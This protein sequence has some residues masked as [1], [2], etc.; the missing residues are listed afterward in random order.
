MNDVFNMPL[1]R[2]L[3]ISD[4]ARGAQSENN[5]GLDDAPIAQNTNAVDPGLENHVPAQIIAY[6][7]IV[8]LEVTLHA[9]SYILIWKEY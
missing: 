1:T 2:S 3:H 9:R 6:R 4:L 5:P 7:W 8:I